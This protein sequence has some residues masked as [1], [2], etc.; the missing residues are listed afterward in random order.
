MKR[1]VALALLAAFILG[2]VGVAQAVEIKAKGTWRVHFNYV[3]NPTFNDAVEIDKFAAMQRA[4]VMF[5]FIAS[6]NLKGVLHVEAGNLRWGGPS[7][8]ALN[9][10][11][12]N[13]KTKHAFVNFKLP[14]TAVDIKA[15][16]QPVAL[17]S[18]LGSHILRADVGAVVTNVPFNDMVGLTFGWARPF[19]EKK[20]NP[21]DPFNKWDDEVDVFLAVLPVTL[22]GVSLKPFAAVTRWGKDSIGSDKNATMWHAGLNFGVTMLDPFAILGDFNYGT[23]KWSNDYKQSGWIAVLAAQLAMD[24]VT[25]QIFFAYESGE[26]SGYLTGGDSKRMPVIGT[27]GGAFGPGIGYGGATSFAQDNFVRSLLVGLDT[28][29]LLFGLNSDPYQTRQGAVGLA[30][31]GAAL[32]NLTFM[33]N[34]S[35]ELV[36][37]YARGTNHKDNGFL[38]TTEDSYWEANFN[39]TYQMYENLALIL[40][41]AYGKV[42]LD[43][44]GTGFRGDLADDG[45][46]RGVLGVV[47]KF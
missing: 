3:N 36:A 31:V 9:T 42:D 23:V 45:L 35:H 22:D 17:P 21:A 19:D 7:G 6:E 30:T 25:P 12:V 26:G 33:D 16:L 37:Y 41:L 13:I 14:G 32:R 38:L 40:E 15:G 24:M 44:M 39:T 2:S 11:G 20:V 8:G 27:D 10:D 46:A 43:D 1:F 28:I 5:S 4:R 29:A 47:Y 18:T 34:M